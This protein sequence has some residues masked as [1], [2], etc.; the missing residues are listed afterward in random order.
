M[1]ENQECSY[2][3]FLRTR[4]GLSVLKPRNVRI[5]AAVVDNLVSEMNRAYPGLKDET[6]GRQVDFIIYLFEKIYKDKVP[7][8]I[9]AHEKK[10][11]KKRK[12]SGP[13]RKDILEELTNA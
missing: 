11:I 7:T 1:S 10:L 3:K 8:F 12:R 9:T 6:F 5:D 2:S 4:S 13:K